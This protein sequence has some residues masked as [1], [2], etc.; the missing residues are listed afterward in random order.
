MFGE[1]KREAEKR[2]KGYPNLDT[3]AALVQCP[4]LRM[5]ELALWENDDYGI[6]RLWHSDIE[7]E[8]YMV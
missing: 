7:L 5:S 3:M 6:M 8:V 1:L 2:V 4:V